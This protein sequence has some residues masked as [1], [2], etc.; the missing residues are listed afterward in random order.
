VSAFGVDVKLS[1]NLELLER[2]K[3]DEDV[4]FVDGIVFS[5]EQEGRR[6]VCTGV[7]AARDLGEGG[8]IDQICGVDGDYEVGA[9]TDGGVG[10]RLAGALEVRVIAEDDDEMAAGGE[11]EDSDAAGIEVPFG[12]MSAGDAHRLLGVLEVGGVVGKVLLDGNSVLGEDAVDSNGVEPGADL[13]AF[14]VVGE[15]TVASAGEDD[16]GGSSVVG[17][18]CGVKGQGG[19]ADVGEVLERLATYEAVRRFGDVGLRAAA[20]GLRGAVGPER[21]GGLLGVTQSG[22]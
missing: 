18:G 21:E 10:C 17:C 9:G 13:G 1:R 4:F 15:D 19:L 8:S 11:A 2:L 7:D 16:D 3:V 20:V 12:S 5:L 6:S 14:E 22:I